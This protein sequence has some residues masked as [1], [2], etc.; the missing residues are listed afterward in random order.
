M[1]LITS[2]DMWNQVLCCFEEK[3]EPACIVIHFTVCSFLFFILISGQCPEM[4]AVIA[5]LISIYSLSFSLS[6]R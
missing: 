4:N 3:E 5:V 1:L 6:S 2:K